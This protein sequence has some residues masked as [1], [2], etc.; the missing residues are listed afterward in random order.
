MTI[1]NANI[2]NWNIIK[3]MILKNANPKTITIVLIYLKLNL[4]TNLNSLKL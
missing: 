4:C 3:F 2:I 1:K